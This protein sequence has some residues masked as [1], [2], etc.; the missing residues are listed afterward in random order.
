MITF[1]DGDL[2]ADRRAV[3][4]NRLQEPRGDTA[5]IVAADSLRAQPPGH[6][7]KTDGGGRWP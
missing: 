3:W 7:H 4:D 1:L 6:R 2:D 5:T